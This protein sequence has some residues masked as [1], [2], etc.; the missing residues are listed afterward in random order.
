MNKAHLIRKKKGIRAKVLGVAKIP[1]LAVYRSSKH[2]YAQLIDDQHNHTL[3]YVSDS[4]ITDAK[5]KTERAYKS[6]QLLADKAK[7]LKISAVR[8]D[9]GGFRYHGRIKALADGARSKGLSF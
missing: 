7:V 1:R 8:F 3:A 9:R 4:L 5:N 6:G 2:M